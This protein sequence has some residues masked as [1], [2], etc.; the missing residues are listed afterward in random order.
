MDAV[1]EDVRAALVEVD[2]PADKDALVAEAERRGAAEATLKA[3][4]AL[5]PVDYRNEAEVIKSIDIDPARTSG[6]GLDK[7]AQARG[8]SHPGVADHMKDKPAPEITQA[9]GSNVGS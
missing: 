1:I 4:R 9:E 6:A 2:Y 5:P 3:L 8:G 7:G